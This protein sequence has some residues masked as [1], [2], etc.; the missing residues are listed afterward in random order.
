MKAVIL[1]RVSSEEQR[2]NN[3]I[4]SQVYRL[5]EYTVRKNLEVI[6]TFE[7]VESSTKGKR[8]QFNE[9]INFIKKQKE[10]IALVADTIDR[11]QRSF[12]EST[13]LDDLRRE[14]KVVLHFYRENLIIDEKSNSADILRWDMGTM[15]A[16]SY[17]TQLSDNVKR[18]LE[19]KVR[20]GEWTS[21]APFGYK[22]ITRENGKKWIVPDENAIV[23]CEIFKKYTHSSHSV[24]SLTKWLY[25]TYD[26][27]KPTSKIH[28][29]LRNP[30]YCGVMCLKGQ[31]LPHSYE[32]IISKELFD[33]AQNKLDGY[34]KAPFNYSEKPFIFR[35]LI[36]CA[37]CGC[38][39]TAEMKKGH[40]YY[41]CTEHKGK[42]GAKWFREEE[43][44]K[45]L[46]DVI[47]R[48]SPTDE[49]YAEVMLALKKANED[50][51]RMR[52]EIHKKIM[53][54][55][56]SVEK[57][58]CRLL[59]LYLDGKVD[60]DLYKIKNEE[61]KN[62]K[63]KHES[64]LAS[65]SKVTND[66]YNRAVDIVNVMKKAPL[67]LESGSEIPKKQQFL[68]LLFSNLEIKNNHLCYSLK[69][70]FN[71]MVFDKNIPDGWG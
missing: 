51:D 17:V 12:R 16:K 55:L 68:N 9:V 40:V 8:K 2:Q 5:N 63:L 49:Q 54:E 33:M 27:S 64:H 46:N 44:I 43:I 66:W 59:D 31:L 48:I 70:P 71:S 14:G 45:Q 69:E 47:V 36:T 65:L 20:R 13:V 19:E 23:V 42:H 3:S 30:F 41:H 6:R 28:K 15:F 53:L 1:A 58:S 22:N 50:K 7:L 62:K 29:I 11:V 25:D 34:H 24:G 32:P 67:V 21:K 37:D 38:R 56:A 4:P 18:G 39:I 57:S 60:E 10:P 26:I 61:L 52:R 35:G